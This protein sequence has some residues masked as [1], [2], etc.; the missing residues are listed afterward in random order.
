[1]SS[2]RSSRSGRST[3]SLALSSRWTSLDGGLLMRRIIALDLDQNREYSLDC[4]PRLEHR[5]YC[6]PRNR[7]SLGIRRGEGDRHMWRSGMRVFVT[8]SSGWIG[9]A[10]V[11]ELIGA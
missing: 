11:P 7:R 3:S 10:L 5:L 8:G 6:D 1:M 2:N 9:S 4:D